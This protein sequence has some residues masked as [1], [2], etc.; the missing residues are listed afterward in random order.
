[1]LYVDY[2]SPDKSELEE[3]QLMYKMGINRFVKDLV[4]Y[5]VDLFL[6]WLLYR[7]MRPQQI[8]NDGNTVANAL[9]FTHDSNSAGK[10]L[11]ESFKQKHDESKAQLIQTQ[12]NEFLAFVIKQW[13]EEMDTEQ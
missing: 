12:A 8:L 7:F 6:L 9:I 13:S 2:V 11:L 3:K 5:Y 1:M 4:D 10:R